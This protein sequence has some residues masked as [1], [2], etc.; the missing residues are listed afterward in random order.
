MQGPYG[1]ALQGHGVH[2][3]RPHTAS[4]PAHTCTAHAAADSTHLLYVRQD[5]KSVCQGRHDHLEELPGVLRAAQTHARAHAK[6]TNTNTDANATST[7]ADTNA[8]AANTKATNANAQ[9]TS[10]STDTKAKAIS[11]NAGTKTTNANTQATDATDADA[12]T[13]ISKPSGT[14]RRNSGRWRR[15]G[16]RRVRCVGFFHRVPASP[17]ALCQGWKAQRRW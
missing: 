1:G 17:P 15:G 14:Q 6:A 16:R 12:A 4:N 7:N 3:L 5:H 9:A 11:T 10:T 2:A 8:Q 13:N